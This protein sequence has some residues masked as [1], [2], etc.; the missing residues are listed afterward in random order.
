MSTI[1]CNRPTSPLTNAFGIYVHSPFCVH[2]CSYCDFYSFTKYG[3]PDFTTLLGAWEKELRTSARWFLE[4]D[5]AMPVVETIFFGGGTPS[6]LSSETLHHCVAIIAELFPLHS[7]AEITLEAN[8]ET[9]TLEKARAWRQSG[10]NRVSLG[11]QSF[12]AKHLASLERLGSAESIRT[13][14]GLVREAGFDDFNLDFIFAIPGQTAEELESD[15][16]QAATLGP[17]HLSFYNLTLTQG[18]R[19]YKELP[20]DDWAADLYD[21]G[22][23]VLEKND[24]A[25]YEIS[26]FAKPGRECRHNLLYWS[27]GDYLGIGPSAASRLFRGGRFLHRKQVA[28][29]PIYTRAAKGMEFDVTSEEQT[30]LEASFLELRKRTGVSVRGF[31]ERYGYDLSTARKYQQYLD[32]G[33]LSR[34]EDTLALTEK[35]FLLADGITRDLV[36]LNFVKS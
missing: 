35:G 7:Q 32:D 17:T 34:H 28:D 36:D 14:A 5:G 15:L 22:K 29:F 25:R 10:F 26:N 20:P 18:H 16:E 23:A 9:V 6:L 19:L 27:G 21:R 12:Q 33:F 13:A 4:H 8:P 11:A 1:D 31:R 3:E 30:V 24:Y 2:K